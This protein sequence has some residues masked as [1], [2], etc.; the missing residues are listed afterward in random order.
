MSKKIIWFA[1][2]VLWILAAGFSFFNGR[3]TVSVVYEVIVAV[4]F[5]VL[6]ILQW[7][8]EKKQKTDENP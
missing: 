4:V 6:G 1:L 8:R 2:A 7:V 5:L 3:N